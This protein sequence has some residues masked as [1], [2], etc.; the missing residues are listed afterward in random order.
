LAILRH[1]HPAYQPGS[2][3]PIDPDENGQCSVQNQPK[4]GL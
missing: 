4:I 1:C 3:S 2:S